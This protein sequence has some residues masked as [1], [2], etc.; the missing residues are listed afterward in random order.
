MASIR[1]RW[2]TIDKDT[3]EKVA[4]ARHGSGRRWLAKYHDA[5]RK[6]HTS[7]FVKKSDAQGWLDE[8]T[9]KIVTGTHVAPRLAKTTVGEWCDQWLAGY[10]T[11]KPRT[12]RQAEVH[13]K[14]IKTEF[15]TVPLGAVRPSQV[16]DWCSTLKANGHADSYVYA[17]HS[18][19]AQIYT[20][21]IEDGLV[22]RN[23]CSRRT[24]PG[25]GEQRA[26]VAT[27]AQVWGL[28]D[29]VPTNIKPA[30][31]LGAFAGLRLREACGLRV[32]DVDFMRGI[33]HPTVQHPADELK[34]DTSKTP[35]PI[36]QSL[37]L[38]LAAHVENL[39]E[40]AEHLLLDRWRGQL[41][42]WT[43]ER[44][45]RAARSAH[46]SPVPDDHSEDCAGCLIPGLS[47]E[48]RFHDLRHYYA[49]L[50]IASGSDVKVVQK[51]VRHASAKTTLD[52][53]G[54]LWPDTD[55]STRA[56]I[57]D[58]IAARAGGSS[59]AST[60]RRGVQTGSIGPTEK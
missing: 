51:R 41:A 5:A 19:L 11:R 35:V 8:Q 34:T 22:A 36:P 39:P 47:E 20:D 2:Y 55:N 45:I 40:S 17:L 46:V 7:A 25:M 18:R 56:A 21:A 50:L 29:A 44:A 28:Y 24:S 26:Y 57:D 49:S 4:T 31:L 12:V 48:F 1:D 37:A 3:G 23:P 38:D 59:A 60:D 10:R 33:V 13:I 32:R 52:T 30:I 6:E 43:L 53:Y 9:A 27:T 54:H 58:V 15:G 42:P 14:K 16:R